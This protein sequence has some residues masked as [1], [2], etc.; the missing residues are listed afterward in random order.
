MKKILSILLIFILQQPLFSFAIEKPS[1]EEFCPEIYYHKEL[2]SEDW[3]E[4]AKYSTA[5]K[6][7]LWC[8]I[9]LFYVAI[10]TYPMAISDTKWRRKQR[11][12]KIIANYNSSVMYWRQREESFNQSLILCDSTKD[13][14][15]CYVQVKMNEQQKNLAIV[16]NH[17]LRGIGMGLVGI[18]AQ[19]ANTNLQLYQMQQN[20]R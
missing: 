11:A 8:G 14:A 1:F 5:Q 4:P 2:L 18:Q 6:A 19:Q 12:K 20:Y 17:L 7:G 10:A 16:N 9:I 13:I 15:S 3:I